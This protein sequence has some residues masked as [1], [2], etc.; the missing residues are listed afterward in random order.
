MWLY[1]P[2][3]VLFPRWM[4]RT[5]IAIPTA[6]R[7]GPLVVA[8]LGVPAFAYWAQESL[9]GNVTTTVITKDDH[10]LVTDGP[11]HYVRHPLYS[12]GV[13]YFSA[14]AVASGSWHLFLVTTL[15]LVVPLFRTRN[16]EAKLLERLGQEYK[17]Y[18]QRTGRF[19]PRLLNLD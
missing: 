6:I 19:V 11:Y 7:W 14:M 18:L 9:A 2:L 16:E 3:Y 13:V 5:T 10:Q 15:V 8:T 4:S 12:A 1:L 17:A